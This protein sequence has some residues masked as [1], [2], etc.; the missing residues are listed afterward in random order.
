[1]FT[2]STFMTPDLAEQGRVLAK[3]ADVVDA[4]KLRT[5]MTQELGTI[6]AENIKRAH[7]WLESGVSIGK[8][9]LAGF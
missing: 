6:N 4:D 9:V 5:T 7:K 8:V 1:M 3:V 2:R